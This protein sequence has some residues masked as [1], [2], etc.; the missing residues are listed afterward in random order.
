MVLEN[1]KVTLF[2][3]TRARKIYDLEGL[4]VFFKYLGPFHMT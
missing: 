1:C 4:K 3:V 2:P